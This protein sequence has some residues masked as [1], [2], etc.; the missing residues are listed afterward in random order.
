MYRAILGLA[1]PSLVL[2]S[3]FGYTLRRLRGRHPLCGTGVTSR[4]LVT[5]MPADCNVRMAA[6]RP[7]PGPRTN[8]STWRRP[9]SRPLRA[10]FSAARCAAKAVDFR[11]PMNPAVPALPHAMGFPCGSVSVMTVLLKVD[12][13]Y[14]RPTG[15]FFRSRRLVRGFLG[16][17]LLS[18]VLVVMGRR[19][20]TGIRF[21]RFARA[22]VR[23]RWP[24]TGSPLR[25]LKP[26]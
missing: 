11:E 15:T 8:A 13:M 7:G 20:A 12:C 10:A 16:I 14:A 4:M 1:G 17:S 2:P 21:G 6:S 26:L 23:V 19:P 18:Y 24:L 22:L 9:C 25:C 5:L 3:T